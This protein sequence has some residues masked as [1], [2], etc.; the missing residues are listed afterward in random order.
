MAYIPL[1]GTKVKLW[2][3]FKLQKKEKKKKK[4]MV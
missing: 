3:D 2:Y 1:I 4:V